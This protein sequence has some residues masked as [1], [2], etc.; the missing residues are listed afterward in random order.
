MSRQSDASRFAVL[1]VL[2]LKSIDI[3]DLKLLEK[4]SSIHLLSYLNKVKMGGANFEQQTNARYYSLKKQFLVSVNNIKDLYMLSPS[5]R[6][7]IQTLY[8]PDVI[9]LPSNSLDR[10]ITC[11]LNLNKLYF[12][13]PEN[14]KVSFKNLMIF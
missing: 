11:T 2:W 7:K 14:V 10:G 12:P 6:K 4:L 3:N 8:I 13:S 5:I 9:T 1:T